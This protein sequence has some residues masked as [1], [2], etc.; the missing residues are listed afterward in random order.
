MKYYTDDIHD[1][2]IVSTLG[3]VLRYVGDALSNYYA[4]R[5]PLKPRLL[6]ETL[7]ALLYIWHNGGLIPYDDFKSYVR[8]NLLALKKHYTQV[9]NIIRTIGFKIKYDKDTNTSYAS[10]SF[11]L[12]DLK[13][14]NPRLLAPEGW[15]LKLVYIPESI[16]NYISSLPVHVQ[17]QII[18]LLAFLA[19]DPKHMPKS[20]D[21]ISSLLQLSIPTIR[22][23]I[24]YLKKHK[25]LLL[26][27]T[28][29]FIRKKHTNKGTYYRNDPINPQIAYQPSAYRY[30]PHKDIKVYNLPQSEWYALPL[31]IRHIRSYKR[32]MEQTNHAIKI[33]K[34]YKKHIIHSKYKDA[35]PSNDAYIS[36]YNIRPSTSPDYSYASTWLLNTT[37]DKKLESLKYIRQR[38]IHQ[39]A[40]YYKP[41]A[42]AIHNLQIRHITP[43][44]LTNMKFLRRQPLLHIIARCLHKILSSHQYLLDNM[45]IKNDINHMI[46]LYIRYMRNQP[47]ELTDINIPDG[48]IRVLKDRNRHTFKYKLLV[49]AVRYLYNIAEKVGLPIGTYKE[50]GRLECRNTSRLVYIHT[51]LLY[52]LQ[53]H[54]Y[55]KSISGIINIDN[56]PL[57]GL[58]GGTVRGTKKVSGPVRINSP[59]CGG[60]DPEDVRQRRWFGADTQ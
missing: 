45:L 58:H 52:L 53:K 37:F 55:V 19:A 2:I 7:N 24:T 54:G 15:P 6:Y 60:G 21:F 26:I 31:T 47:L 39:L 42:Q 5:S 28:Y 32:T 18:T 43:R 59:P 10:F 4:P 25:L 48:K 36:V 20:Q 34:Y 35:S 3:G 49:D 17:T 30:I 16:H 14:I 29:H 13:D 1:C 33:R 41:I 57:A 27:P 50:F 11:S 9:Y 8:Q 22:R 12:K 56:E 23:H 46:D 51:S 38:H 44:R 40:H